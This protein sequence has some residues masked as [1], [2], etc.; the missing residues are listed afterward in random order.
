MVAGDDIAVEAEAGHEQEPT[1]ERTANVDTDL[2]VQGPLRQ[3][4]DVAGKLHI[5]RANLNIPN[6]LPPNVAVLEDRLGGFEGRFGNDRDEAVDSDGLL[7][8]LVEQ[9][10]TAASD[11][12]ARRMRVDDH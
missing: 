9:L 11:A 5:N 8:R 6:A 2:T 3:K 10:D 4:L 7:N 1:R 12:S